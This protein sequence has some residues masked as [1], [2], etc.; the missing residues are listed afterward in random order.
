VL[1]FHLTTDCPHGGGSTRGANLRV[2]FTA[3]GIWVCPHPLLGSAAVT[4]LARRCA[5]NELWAMAREARG[6]REFL[7][8]FRDW[9]ALTRGTLFF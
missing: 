6:R 4:S 1:A 2:W 3:D 7:G 8:T 9:R 5:G